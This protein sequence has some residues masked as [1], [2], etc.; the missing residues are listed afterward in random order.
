MPIKANGAVPSHL[1][2]CHPS[3]APTITP[4]TSSDPTRIP[5]DMALPV[6]DPELAAPASSCKPPFADAARFA[7]SEPDNSASRAFRAASSSWFW[8]DV[9]KFVPPQGGCFGPW[10]GRRLMPN[11]MAGQAIPLWHPA[12]ACCLEQNRIMRR[13]TTPYNAMTLLDNPCM[14]QGRSRRTCSSEIERT[15]FSPEPAVKNGA[16]SISDCFSVYISA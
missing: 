7:S 2:N 14:K 6:A 16:R 8:S 12:R 4:A 9:P 13:Q 11:E 1:S 15:I 10:R 5:A 3:S